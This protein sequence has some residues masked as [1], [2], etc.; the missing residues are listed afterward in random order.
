M[1]NKTLNDKRVQISKAAESV[2]K[3][4]VK[5]TFE[6]IDELE[7]QRN[8]IQQQIKILKYD[9]YDLKDGRMDRIAERQRIDPD[10][11]KISCVLV[12]EIPGQST[13]SPWHVEYN[14]ALISGGDNNDTMRISN[15][16]T[17]TF[18]SGT[19]RM[20]NGEAKYL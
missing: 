19:Y 12:T 5:E 4:A 8:L 16:M 13:V 1:D 9:L 10:T 2:I 6:H 11:M 17:K 20:N 3:R 15:S 14:V 7:T 18:A